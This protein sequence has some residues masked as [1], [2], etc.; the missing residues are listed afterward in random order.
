M[1]E[2]YLGEI[3]MFA[4]NFAPVGWEKCEG[5]LINI[6]EN[7]ALFALLSTT[8]GGDGHTTFGLPDLRGRLPIHK[9]SNQ[10]STYSLGMIGGTES[11]TLQ[12]SQLPAHTHTAIA[13]Q[14]AGSDASPQNNTW[15][16]AAVYSTG[17]DGN[18]NPLS[19]NPLNNNSTSYLGD[20]LPHSNMMPSV[21]LSFIIALQGIF[22][23]QS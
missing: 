22:P 21:T 4:G 1:S 6:S 13:A 10:G 2:A 11:V 14:A 19:R 15:A 16:K 20:S 12:A 8:Y 7:D 3:R 17:L 18:N 9:G 5:Q 23:S